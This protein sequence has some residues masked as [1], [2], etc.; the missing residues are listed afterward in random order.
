[1]LVIASTLLL[2]LFS[3]IFS[4]AF[5]H[6]NTCVAD[7]LVQEK[8]HIMDDVDSTHPLAQAIHFLALLDEKWLVSQKF[9]PAR[10][11]KQKELIA[12]L[13]S[14]APLFDEGDQSRFQE[15]QTIEPSAK[16]SK[17]KFVHFVSKS[18]GISKNKVLGILKEK[19]IKSRQL[20]RG[21]AALILYLAAKAK[22]Q[23][24]P[25][26]IFCHKGLQVP[27]KI[28]S[29][30]PAP[31]S[32][33]ISVKDETGLGLTL[34]DGYQIS[35][36]S[37]PGTGPLRF[38]AF[39]PDGI[40]FV[41]KPTNEG[42][43]A[44]NKQGGEVL[45]LPDANKDGKADE[46]KHVITGLS[47]RPHGITFH[48]GY[49]YLAEEN[50][51]T[52]YKYLQNAM[53]G[54]REEI[55]NLPTGNEHVSRTIGFGP[56]GKMYVSV[57]S[58]CNV[59]RETRRENAA[60]LQFNADGTGQKIFAEGLRNA[61]GF[62]FHPTTGAMWATDN[63]RDY[64]G[65]DLPPDEI[66]IVK[67]GKHYG[68]PYCYGKNFVDPEFNNQTFC[69]T[70]E[71][72]LWSIQAH[73]ATLGLR[74]I[75]GPQFSDWAGDLFVAFHGSWNRSIPTGY[76]IV[77]LDVSGNTIVGEKDFVTGWLQ[78]SSSTARPVDLIFDSD[79]ALY[80]TSDNKEGAIYRIS[81][82]P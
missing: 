6:E 77:R 65:D 80:M 61:V 14:Y 1:M 72:A 26:E 15:L 74:F 4:T 29:L 48:N 11:L 27:A 66:N 47:N 3:I 43:Y 53:V 63:G 21:E 82:I 42:L 60:I 31:P 75:E 33:E 37:S 32:V 64:L 73:S 55:V 7:L 36:F 56:D 17:K 12:M 81:K 69:E 13:Q 39:S 30:P 10:K 40:L 68:W 49:L 9:S 70:T 5:A 19:K 41:T 2:L 46:I 67:E 16:V 50:K 44:E 58:S 38:M 54:N 24:I 8:K 35:Y 57:G 52:R 18:M 20:K 51:V 22:F 76:K 45:A 25:E 78:G 23:D 79:G 34:P 62:I 71:P 59:C 28:K